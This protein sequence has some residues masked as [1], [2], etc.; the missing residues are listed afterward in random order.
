MD[1][2]RN[3]RLSSLISKLTTA[4]NQSIKK[5]PKSRKF[6]NSAEKNNFHAPLNITSL[7]TNLRTS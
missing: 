1:A 3:S 2:K 4:A 5:D 6:S 7:E